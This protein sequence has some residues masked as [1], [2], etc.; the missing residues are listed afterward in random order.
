MLGDNNMLC[1]KQQA[2]RD[3]D[4]GTCEQ[5]PEGNKAWSVWISGGRAFQM[6]QQVERP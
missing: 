6:E 1:K 4:K 5:R 3:R 2:K